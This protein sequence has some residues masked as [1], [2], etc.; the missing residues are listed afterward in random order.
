[1]HERIKTPRRFERL[2][3][4]QRLLL[5]LLC[6]PGT[7]SVY[8]GVNGSPWF[9]V[10]MEMF[11]VQT[12][13][14]HFS[15]NYGFHM[16]QIVLFLMLYKYHI[17]IHFISLLEIIFLVGLLFISK[18]FRKIHFYHFRFLKRTSARFS[19]HFIAALIKINTINT[20]QK[21]FRL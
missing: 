17:R 11:T 13:C 19:I 14:V 6:S 20:M 5:S 15:W 10:S 4:I 2:L 16:Q 8:A 21:V 18:Y 12:L 1:M 7:F 9:S 3:L